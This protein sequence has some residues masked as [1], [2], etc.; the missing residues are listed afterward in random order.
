M[1][2]TKI[3]GAISSGSEELDLAWSTFASQILDRPGIMIPD[4]DDD[5]SWHA[6]LGHSIDMQGVRA[7][8]FVGVDALTRTAPQFV[9]LNDRGIGVAQLAG[10][11]EI[12]AIRDHLLSGLRGVPFDTTLDVLRS[13]GG[14]TGSSLAEAFQ[15]FP[16][17]KFHWAVRAYLQNSAA[18]KDYDYSFRRWLEAECQLLGVSRFPPSDFRQIVNVDGTDISVEAALV[19]RLQ[20]SF[21]Q[22]GPAMAPYMICDWQLWLWNEG[23]TGVFETFKP[24]EFHLQFVQKYGRGVIPSEPKGF[25]PWWL[26]LFPDLPP[27]LANECIWLAVEKG[28]V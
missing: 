13:E 11:W 25:V 24:D 3:A 23:L 6:F 28:L 20:Q 26:G 22:V 2:T 18:L 9:P 1:A 21:F 12:S 14:S 8:E 27:R 7:A 19:R 17:R 4:T 5:L 15:Y 16:W 10:L